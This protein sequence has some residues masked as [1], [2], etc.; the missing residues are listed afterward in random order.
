MNSTFYVIVFKSVHYAIKSEHILKGQYQIKIMPTP[1]EISASC[2]V[3]IRI[4]KTDFQAIR[5]TLQDNN[6]EFTIYEMVDYEGGKK[7]VLIE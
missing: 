1:R 3:S 7:A 6:E 4:R 2:G 5:N